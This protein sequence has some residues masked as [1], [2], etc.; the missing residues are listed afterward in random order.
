M[1]NSKMLCLAIHCI[2]LLLSVEV[3]MKIRSV[4]AKECLEGLD[5]LPTCRGQEA[6]Q[7]CWI[8]CQRKHG[9]KAEAWCRSILPGYPGQVCMCSYPC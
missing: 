8:E 2:I 5:V 1:A 9:P 4:D 7:G 3:M 6:D